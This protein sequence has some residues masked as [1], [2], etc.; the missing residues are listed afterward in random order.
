MN[1]AKIACQFSGDKIRDT[2][3]KDHTYYSEQIADLEA[4]LADAQTNLRLLSTNTGIIDE[5]EEVITRMRQAI[6]TDEAANDA[7]AE[8]QYLNKRVQ[9]IPLLVKNTP[10]EVPGSRRT[11]S[12]DSLR[13]Q[14]LRDQVRRYAAVYTEENPLLIAA[15]E[16]LVSL[17]TE[18]ANR[19]EG[20]TR[21]DTMMRN[22]VL[23]VLQE[24]LAMLQLDKP[25]LLKEVNRLRQKAKAARNRLEEL[26][27]AIALFQARTKD[28]DTIANKLSRLTSRLSEIELAAGLNTSQLE[29]VETANARYAGMKPLTTKVAIVAGG[30]FAGINIVGVAAILLWLLCDTRIHKPSDCR[31]AFGCDQVGHLPASDN[32]DYATWLARNA[33]NIADKLQPLW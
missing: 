19:P 25:R 28:R 15:R 12:E 3:R 27:E 5:G 4:Q 9:T 20:P 33:E 24:E 17:E 18:L 11:I 2:I 23:D 31:F 8:L 6:E 21:A 1:Y 16:E 13:L 10:A 7:L 30:A 29:I 14:S 22:P 32:P 26:P